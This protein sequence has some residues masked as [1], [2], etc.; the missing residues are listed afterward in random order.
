[1]LFNNPNNKDILIS[2]I[3]SLLDFNNSEYIVDI[4]LQDPNILDS[5][6]N[7]DIRCSTKCNKVILIQMVRNPDKDIIAKQ[8]FYLANI[9][10][11]EDNLKDI[12]FIILSKD[13]LFHI[14]GEE[15]FKDTE[16]F[17]QKTANTIIKELNQE[18]PGFKS[19]LKI[20]EFPKFKKYL[21]EKNLHNLTV[22][23]QWLYFLTHCSEISIEDIPEYIDDSVRKAY[24]LMNRE[25]WDQMTNINYKKKLIEDKIIKLEE[26]KEI[27]I[28]EK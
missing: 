19:Y 12:Y 18:L 14:K 22:K 23:Q 1:M 16:I 9:F 13:I 21:R 28:S 17:Y 15:Q 3:N 10:S 11:I 25:R 4:E 7:V 8:E 2:L 20:F 24:R 27:S 5:Q 26:S 6:C